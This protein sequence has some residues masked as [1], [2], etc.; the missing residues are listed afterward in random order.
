MK[1]TKESLMYP[2]YLCMVKSQI[3]NF[4]INNPDAYFAYQIYVVLSKMQERGWQ[5][6]FDALLMKVSEYKR[7]AFEVF[8]TTMLDET[9]KYTETF[10]EVFSE[11][12]EV[13]TWANIVEMHQFAREYLD[14]QNGNN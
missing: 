11:F 9:N 2:F 13:C 10:R 14:I 4:N 12:L 7:Y 8:D 5:C 3:S 6:S 1:W